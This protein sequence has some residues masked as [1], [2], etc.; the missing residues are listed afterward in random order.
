MI[1]WVGLKANPSYGVI[2]KSFILCVLFMAAWFIKHT[3]V[4]C[5]LPLCTYHMGKHLA[6]KQMVLELVQCL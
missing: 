4:A 5:V 1:Y 3:F 2:S 6:K